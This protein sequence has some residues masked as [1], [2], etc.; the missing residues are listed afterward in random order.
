MYLWLQVAQALEADS[1]E[2][3]IAVYRDQIDPMV[4]KTNN[5]AYDEA[6]DIVRRVRDPMTRIGKSAE[7]AAWIDELRVRHKAKRNF[8]K[9]LDGVVSERASYSEKNK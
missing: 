4:Q 9:R 7:F 5:Q 3:A 2:D 6:A 1:P 8:V